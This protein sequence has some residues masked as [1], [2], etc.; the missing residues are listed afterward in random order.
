MVSR[1]S[2][3]SH[4]IGLAAAAPPLV[5]A[6]WLG[7]VATWEARPLPP[8]L[9]GGL[10][11]LH[12]AQKCRRAP[13]PIGRSVPVEAA[14][15]GSLRLVEQGTVSGIPDFRNAGFL[16]TL[17]LALYL[18][19]RACGRLLAYGLRRTA[20]AHLRAAPASA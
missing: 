8:C 12:P 13:V 20:K 9:A 10:N 3:W 2:R 14:G 5:L 1:L 6:L 15:F 17:S 16:A 11:P 18:T 7:G 4:R 19:S